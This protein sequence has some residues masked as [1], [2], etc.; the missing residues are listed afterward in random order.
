M[1]TGLKHGLPVKIRTG[2]KQKI[3]VLFVIE[4]FVV[5]GRYK[6]FIVLYTRLLPSKAQK[7]V[8]VDTQSIL[9]LPK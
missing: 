9:V 6:R 2:K 3:Q 5:K 1:G 7:H 4:G 8:A